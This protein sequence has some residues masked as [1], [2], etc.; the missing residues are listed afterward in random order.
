MAIKQDD[1]LDQIFQRLAKKSGKKR[2]IVGIARRLIGRIR[3][4]INT[5]SLYQKNSK[6]ETEFSQEKLAR[7]P[8][9]C[10]LVVTFFSFFY[11]ASYCPQGPQ[12]HPS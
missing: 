10:K 11:S 12:V 5:G 3:S 6:Q 9:F 2:A 1:S 4:C 8:V 7:P